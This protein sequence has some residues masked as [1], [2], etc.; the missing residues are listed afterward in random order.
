MFF[1][2]SISP[3]WWEASFFGYGR[4]LPDFWLPLFLRET[5]RLVSRVISASFSFEFSSNYIT[6]LL[7]FG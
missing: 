1:T 6:S 5:L 7:E 3:P 2:W 4:A